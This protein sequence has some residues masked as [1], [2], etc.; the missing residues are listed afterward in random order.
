MKELAY[1]D[2]NECWARSKED[3]ADSDDNDEKHSDDIDNN[4]GDNNECWA[5]TTMTMVTIM[6]VV[7][8]T[9]QQK[10]LWQSRL[11]DNNND[12]WYLT[13]FACVES[14]WGSTWSTK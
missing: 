4:D 7:P 9:K 2:D 1:G 14:V 11:Y 10:N 8:V 13:D 5:I 3:D 6:R 12:D